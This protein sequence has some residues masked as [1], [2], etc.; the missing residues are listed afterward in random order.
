MVVSE[1]GRRKILSN[2]FT[3]VEVNICTYRNVEQRNN[4]IYSLSPGIIDLFSNPPYKR[5]N[6]LHVFTVSC[7]T[8]QD[9]RHIKKDQE[10]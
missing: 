6:I 7:K 3:F 1:I 4:K 9:F 10:E 8:L 2:T 5:W